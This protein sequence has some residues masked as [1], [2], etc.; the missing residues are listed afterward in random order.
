M[1][2]VFY[3]AKIYVEKGVYAQAMLVDGGIIRSI[4]TD[5]DI[6]AQTADE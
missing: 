6:L 3:N 1:K 5:E 4:G 2:R